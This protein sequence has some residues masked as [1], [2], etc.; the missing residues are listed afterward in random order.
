MFRAD[1]LK[2]IGKNFLRRKYFVK[3]EALK[4]VCIKEKLSFSF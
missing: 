4:L 2:I 1:G 3:F